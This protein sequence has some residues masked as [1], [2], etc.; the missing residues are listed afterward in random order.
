LVEA[1]ETV[2]PELDEAH[3]AR[4]VGAGESSGRCREDHLPRLAQRSNAGSAAQGGSGEVVVE[5]DGLAGVD[6]TVH[7]DAATCEGP[8]EVHAGMHGVARPVE[9]RHRGV[10]LEH[11]ADAAPTVAL[12]CAV[13]D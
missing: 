5:Y 12:D 11:V 9:D 4:Q 6:P 7:L 13:H 2:R 8:L 10:A 3:I 1:V